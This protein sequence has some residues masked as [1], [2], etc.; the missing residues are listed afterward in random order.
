MFIYSRGIDQSVSLNMKVTS[1]SPNLPFSWV[2]YLREWHRNPKSEMCMSSPPLPSPTSVTQSPCTVNSAS[3][4]PPSLLFHYHYTVQATSKCLL[5]LQQ[6][7]NCYPDS[8]Q[9]PS[10]ACPLE[11]NS[12]LLNVTSRPSRTATVCRSISCHFLLAFCAPATLIPLNS[13]FP[14]AFLPFWPLHT[15]LSA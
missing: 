11:I 14:D 2:P 3:Q 1:F 5:T 7:P 15:L 6:P 8:G 4:L 9:D 10:I 12:K 13:R